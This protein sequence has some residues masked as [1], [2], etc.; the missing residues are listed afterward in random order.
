MKNL[1]LHHASNPQPECQ[2]IQ[3]CEETSRK[4]AS[5]REPTSYKHIAQLDGTVAGALVREAM[6][7]E[8][9]WIINHGKV[10]PRDKNTITYLKEI[11]GQWVVKFKKTSD[12]LLDRVR[13]RWVLRGDR[14]RPHVDYD[15]KTISSPVATKTATLTAL[16]IAVQ[17]NLLLYGVDVSKAFTVSPIDPPGLFMAVH[18]GVD[19]SNPDKC[20]KIGLTQ[21]RLNVST[22]MMKWTYY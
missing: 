15:P 5:S 2:F 21:I 18:K 4:I 17:Y 7:D 6:L 3:L 12:G 8:V 22:T 11:D 20:T 10:V 14:Q 19:W 1:R 13:A 16:T 9:V